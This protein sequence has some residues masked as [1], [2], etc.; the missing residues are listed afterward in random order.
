VRRAKLLTLVGAGI[1]VFLLI[2]ALLTHIFS[3]DGAE[4]SAI[5][6]LVQAEAKGDENAMLARMHG[7]KEDIS[8]RERVAE[9]A[10]RLRHAG[11]VSILTIQT[12]AG[13]S[14]AGTTGAARV[15]WNVGNS[16]PIVQCVRVRRAG[17]VLSGFTV[18]LQA[19][20]PKLK[21]DAPCPSQ[22]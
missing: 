8:C 16:L 21:G 17:N 3:V 2:T 12:S 20:T 18:E 15:A 5:T 9:D 14:L 6:S 10:A 7:C 1:I 4:R 19:I 13:F 22:I 11:H